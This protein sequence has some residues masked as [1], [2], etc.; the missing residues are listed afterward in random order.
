MND[1][2]RERIEAHLDDNDIAI[3]EQRIREETIAVPDLTL[4]RIAV[5]NGQYCAVFFIQPHP[6]YGK[7]FATGWYQSLNELLCA[8][9]DTLSTF[10][11][12][13]RGD[14]D[15]NIFSAEM[16]EYLSAE[17]LPTGKTVSLTITEVV[18]ESIAGPRG[19][20]NK[21]TVSFRERPKKLILNKTNARALA[22]A[23]TPE[24][25]NWRGATVA[26][27]VEN[28]KVGRN[29]VPSIRVKGATPAGR[30]GAPAQQPV[31]VPA[32]GAGNDDTLFDVAP[33]GGGGAYSE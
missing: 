29:T 21:V 11:Y 4:E 24:T 27:G 25:D 12:V 17:M 8:V 13:E 20:S 15:M 26:L 22:H 1:P 23:L 31:A 28:V 6:S 19:E 32:N 10:T 18:Q 3:A 7:G 5:V 33:V 9:L 30:N 14:D 16:F 2:A